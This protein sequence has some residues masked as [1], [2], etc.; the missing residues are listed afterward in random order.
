M[1]M[2]YEDMLKRAKK[3]LPEMKT[4]GRFE[5]PRANVIN[6]KRQTFVKNFADVAKTLRR[7]P[8]HLA[9]FLFK[10]L[11]IPG[12]IRGSEL[13]LQGKVPSSIVNQ[14][15]K[16]YAEEYVIC[17][18]CGKPDTSMTKEGGITTVRCE[19]CGARRT[20]KGIN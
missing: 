10:E 4:G 12:S 20:F 5:L 15:I 7:E 11:A 8:N 18:E 2:E 9:K 3:N 19:A 14:R 17:K 16:D 1:Y 13:V 6:I